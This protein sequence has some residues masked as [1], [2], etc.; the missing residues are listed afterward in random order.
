MGV[1]RRRGF[2]PKGATGPDV[3]LAPMRGRPWSTAFMRILC[4]LTA[5]EATR[6]ICRGRQARSLLLPLPNGNLASAASPNSHHLSLAYSDCYKCNKNYRVRRKHIR[7]THPPHLTPAY[8]RPLSRERQNTI[9][10][11]PTLQTTGMIAHCSLQ[12]RGR[13]Q[14]CAQGVRE[15]LTMC[16][17]WCRSRRPADRVCGHRVAL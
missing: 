10:R 6:A 1:C 12:V 11:R 4:A 2:P 14:D 7:T 17:G 8:A 3:L 16:G 15:C 5:P 13:F 9:T